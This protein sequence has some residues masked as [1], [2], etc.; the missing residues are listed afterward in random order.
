MKLLY[1]QSTPK[2][3]FASVG[4]DLLETKH[5]KPLVAMDDLPTDDD[6][7]GMEP[8]TKPRPRSVLCTQPFYKKT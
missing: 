3:P 7:I 2:S 5:K 8:E 4:E 6:V 1:F